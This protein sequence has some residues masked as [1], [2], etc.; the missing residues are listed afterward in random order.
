MQRTPQYF[1]PVYAPVQRYVFPTYPCISF[2]L[3]FRIVCRSTS[4]NSFSYLIWVT[5]P[6]PFLLPSSSPSSHVSH[7]WKYAWV[8]SRYSISSKIYTFHSITPF[9]FTKHIY[10][11][12][13][14]T[15]LV[16]PRKNSQFHHISDINLQEHS[17]YPSSDDAL[18]R[19]NLPFLEVSLIKN[20]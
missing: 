10:F 3:L 11:I 5:R 6:K 14:P 18:L 12:S 9:K 13:F 8:L 15:L 20:R 19:E 7:L 2:G 1:L 16:R 4:S 17:R